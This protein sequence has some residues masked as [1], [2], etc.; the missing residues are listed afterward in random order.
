[1]PP[2]VERLAK[3]F[4]RRPAIVNIGTVGRPQE[5]VEQITFMVTE[6]EKRYDQSSHYYGS[7][8]L[9]SCFRYKPDAINCVVAKSELSYACLPYYPFRAQIFIVSENW[10][11]DLVFMNE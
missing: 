9:L 10:A 11:L 6:T 5:R 7:A 1:M 8:F 2:T 3:T 4:L